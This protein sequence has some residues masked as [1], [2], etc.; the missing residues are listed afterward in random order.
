MTSTEVPSNAGSGTVTQPPAGPRSRPLLRPGECRGCRH[1]NTLDCAG[2]ARAR[3]SGTWRS[4]PSGAA[5]RW[6]PRLAWSA[7]PE[8]HGGPPCSIRGTGSSSTSASLET[9]Y[10]VP[11]VWRTSFSAVGPQSSSTS[12][13]FRHPTAASRCRSTVTSSSRRRRSDDTPRLVR[14]SISCANASAPRSPAADAGEL[15]PLPSVRVVRPSRKRVAADCGV[16][17]TVASRPRAA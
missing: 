6:L 1:A 2:S 3:G 13:S 14:L 8:R 4:S 17:V 10:P 9:M 7:T 15:A 12:S 5:T 11:S 16:G